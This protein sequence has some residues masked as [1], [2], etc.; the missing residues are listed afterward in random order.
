[1][2]KEISLLL[3]ASLLTD[4]KAAVV[5]AVY[6]FT[7]VCNVALLGSLIV[8]GVLAWIDAQ[9]EGTRE[10][11]DQDWALMRMRMAQRSF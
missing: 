5:S 10:N 4:G 8:A 7:V 3:H 2:F 11:Q 6:T 1:M 9:G